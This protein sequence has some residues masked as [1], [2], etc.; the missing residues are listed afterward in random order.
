LGEDPERLV[1]HVAQRPREG[2]G[3]RGAVAASRVEEHAR[4]GGGREPLGPVTPESGA[5]EPLVE[6]HDGRRLVGAGTDP[7]GFETDTVDGDPVS[8]LRIH[9]GHFFLRGAT[10]FTIRSSISAATAVIGPSLAARYHM[11]AQLSIPNTN[12]VTCRL[13]ADSRA[14]R[15]FDGPPSISSAMASART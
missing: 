4:P 7:S 10:P 11:K 2:D 3:I 6:H 13:R 1:L 5:A 9:R 12:R 14:F 8:H 15:L